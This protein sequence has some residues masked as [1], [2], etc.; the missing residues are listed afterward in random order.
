MSLCFEIEFKKNS[1]KWRLTLLKE[2]GMG[3]LISLNTIVIN[4]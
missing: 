4:D 2:I 3:W 1:G